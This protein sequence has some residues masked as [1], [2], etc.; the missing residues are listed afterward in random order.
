MKIIKLIIIASAGLASWACTPSNAGF[1]SL[2]NSDVVELKFFVDGR[3]F[4]I[5][6]SNHI[7][8]EFA[9]GN[10]K[11]KIG[12]KDEVSLMVSPK[13]TTVFDSTGLSCFAVA[14]FTERSSGG[15]VRIKELFQHQRVFSPQE[16]ITVILGS[17]LPQK[18]PNDGKVTRIQQIDCDDVQD[19]PALEAL[20]ANA[21]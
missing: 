19:I 15:P 6:P 3:P 13:M 14:D 2:V 16:R 20:L 4:S 9:P 17:F 21:K 7:T 8:K 1:I 12:D 10:H 11:V 18:A 5:L